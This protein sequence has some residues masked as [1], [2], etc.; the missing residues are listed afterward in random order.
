[1]KQEKAENSHK[2]KKTRANHACCNKVI[3]KASPVMVSLE[4][5]LHDD[6]IDK[7][8]TAVV[9][10]AKKTYEDVVAL[11]SKAKKNLASEEPSDWPEGFVDS[12]P[13]KVSKWMDSANLLSAQLAA[14]KRLSAM[15]GEGTD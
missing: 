11:M 10:P 6:N 12:F 13:G 14:I 5:D 7:V 4:R 9:T 1:M 8:P 3:S 2:D 15:Q